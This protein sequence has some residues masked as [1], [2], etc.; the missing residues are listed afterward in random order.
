FEV[1]WNRLHAHTAWRRAELP[2]Y[3]FQ[4]RRYWH[5]ASTSSDTHRPESFRPKA[6]F[7]E[8]L[9]ALSPEKRNQHLIA[10]LRTLLAE[11]LGAAAAASIPED[12]SL[13]DHDL[14][15]LRI[16]DFLSAVQTAVD[17]VCAPE[18]LIRRPTLREFAGYLE[19]RLVRTDSTSEP[20]TSPQGMWAA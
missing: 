1:D 7:R 4:R 17:C 3:A 19:Q 11:L 13:L 8:R 9:L 10:R 20:V 18:D 16:L 12:G 15:S 6:E 14:D 5:A 2:T